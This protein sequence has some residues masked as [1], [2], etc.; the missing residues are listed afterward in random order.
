MKLGLKILKLVPVLALCMGIVAFAESGA[1]SGKNL[2]QC[3]ASTLCNVYCHGPQGT[4]V[5]GVAPVSCYA[6]ASVNEPCSWETKYNVSVRCIGANS[7]G[8]WVNYY[9]TCQF[10]YGSPISQ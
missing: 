6:K 8:R 5:C 4:F 1:D 3:Y 7:L 10:F 9:L 2:N